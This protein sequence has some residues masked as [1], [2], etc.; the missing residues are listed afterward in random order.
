MGFVD[1]ARREAVLANIVADVRKN[2]LTAGDVGYRYLLRALANGGCS[3]VIFAMKHQSEKLGYGYQLARGAT[4]LAEAWGARPESSQNHFM[5]GQI[6]EW[7]YHDLAGIQPDPSGPGFKRIVI[8]PAIVG[9]L[10][11]VK[12]AYASPHGR[13]VSAWKREGSRLTLE[14][15]VPANST[16]IVHAPVSDPAAVTE[17]GKPVGRA[18]GARARPAIPGH[19]VFEVGSGSYRFSGTA[20]IASSV[21]F[22]APSSRRRP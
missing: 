1:T 8:K 2:G 11:W 13:I 16:A 12:A 18:R 20:P 9:D 3:D 22:A 21:P 15:T 17:G 7:F 14:I 10:A 6:N 19:A 4:S 5:L